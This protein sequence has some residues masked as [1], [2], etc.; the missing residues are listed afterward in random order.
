MGLVNLKKGLK[1]LDKNQLVALIADLYKKNKA[2]R[3][4]LDFYVQP[5]EQERFE[6]Y[7]VR[8][9]EAFFPKRGHPLRLREGKQAISDFRQL[10]PA[11]EL[12]TEQLPYS[13]QQPELAGFAQWLGQFLSTE[14]FR[15]FSARF[16]RLGQALQSTADYE[17]RRALLDARRAL[18]TNF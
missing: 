12:L 6:K 8:V 13:S 9:V 14:K 18:E 10:E 11:A 3:E 17:T 1:T 7:Q 4:Y 5:N 16:L 15:D 2:A